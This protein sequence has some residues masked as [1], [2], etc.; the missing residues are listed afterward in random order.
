MNVD[1]RLV[2]CIQSKRSTVEVVAELFE[3]KDNP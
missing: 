3:C 2:I 1:Q